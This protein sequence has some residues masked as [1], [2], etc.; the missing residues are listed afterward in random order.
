MSGAGGRRSREVVGHLPRP[1]GLDT[2]PRG[3]SG[4]KQD[5]GRSWLGGVYE[6]LVVVAGVRG[7]GPGGWGAGSH[8]VSTTSTDSL[9]QQG[10]PLAPGREKEVKGVV[11][12]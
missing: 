8:C 2:A 5:G 11:L 10:N 4:K 12:L 3:D 1:F 7:G 9:L 6:N